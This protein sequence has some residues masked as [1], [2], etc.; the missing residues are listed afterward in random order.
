MVASDAL[1]HDRAR[2][3][4]SNALYGTT[5]IRLSTKTVMAMVVSSLAFLTKCSTM[6]RSSPTTGKWKARLQR[7]ELALAP[8]SDGGADPRLVDLVR[9]LARRAARQWLI[10]QVERQRREKDDLPLT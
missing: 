2:E 4:H 10:E 9:I 5:S 8:G 6:S 7:Q 1:S 3:H